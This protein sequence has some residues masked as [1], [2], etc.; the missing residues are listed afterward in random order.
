[1]IFMEIIMF[2]LVTILVSYCLGTAVMNLLERF[3]GNSNRSG[4]K[5]AAGG[6]A[7]LLLGSL[8]F[9]VAGCVGI[10]AGFAFVL[11]VLLTSI[12]FLTSVLVCKK[13]NKPV[14]DRI[15]KFDFRDKKRILIA[16]IFVLLVVGQIIFVTMGAYNNSEAIKN[17]PVAT[18]VFEN[19]YCVKGSPL[20]NLWGAIAFLSGIHPLT[21]I[22]T[23][24]P[25]VIFFLVYIGYY[26]LAHASFEESSF[27]PIIVVGVI[28]VLNVW[29]YQSEVFIPATLLFSWFSGW[30]FIV[31]LLTVFVASVI[32]TGR[33][34]GYLIIEAKEEKHTED[35]DSVEDEDYQ[36]E[37][38]MKKHKIIN[39]RNLAIAL[40]LMA[41]MLV[42]VVLVLNNKIN[43]LHAATA[44]LQ[45]DLNNRCRVYEF[46]ASNGEVCGY[47]IKGKDEKLTMIGGGG[48]ERA[49]DLYN[50][51][52]EYG[53]VITNWY[54]YDVTEENVGACVKCISEKGIEAKNIY[55]LNR[56]EIEGL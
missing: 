4:L 52:S 37:W 5:I 32:L 40:G 49:D 26:E 38:D 44:N 39:A 45:V 25:A 18:K 24:L 34:N 10:S 15:G 27:A 29:G 41:V 33:I 20:M 11:L 1:M 23:Y 21:L 30:C 8:V 36:E 16:F 51:I 28:S 47:L 6:N 3:I 2:V 13:N 14:F 53:T 54:L 7:L 43:Q 35:T 22:Y 9:L 12:L 42:A 46:E 50:F 31:H 19:G 56:T 17:I 48:E 55:V